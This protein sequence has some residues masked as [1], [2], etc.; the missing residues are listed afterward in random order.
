M[1]NRVVHGRPRGS[2]SH[3]ET[4]VAAIVPSTISN[5]I[6]ST[7]EGD[8]AAIIGAGGLVQIPSGVAREPVGMTTRDTELRVA[9]NLEKPRYRAC[10][11]GTVLVSGPA[12]AFRRPGTIVQDGKRDP[13][14]VCAGPHVFKGHFDA[15]PGP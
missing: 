1:S 3:P 10:L 15:M 2:V 13:D 12:I 11:E 14:I 4:P 8:P 7:A 5:G 6:P 9:A